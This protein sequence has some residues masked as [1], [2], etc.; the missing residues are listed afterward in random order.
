MYQQCPVCGQRT[1]L[2]PGFWFGTGYVSYG[3]SVMISGFNLA[4]FWVF[5]G[6]SWRNNSI[7]WYLGVNAITLVVIQPWMMR[8]SRV[9]Y[10]NLFVKYVPGAGHSYRDNPNPKQ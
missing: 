1:E 6:I 4:W 5:F 9:I 3:L 7:L 10:L 2:E 8:L